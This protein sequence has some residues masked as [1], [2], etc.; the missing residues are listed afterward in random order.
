MKLYL[1]TDTWN[2]ANTAGGSST[3]TINAK[4]GCMLDLQI[5][6]D[7]DLAEGAT[8]VLTCKPKSNYSSTVIA[9]DLAWTEI[10]TG[11]G[12]YL[13]QLDLNTSDALALFSGTSDSVALMAD[14]TITAGGEVHKTQTFS[15]V[16]G[17][18]V[19]T[20]DD[21]SP[22]EVPN[23]KAVLADA[24]DPT[25]DTHWTTQAKVAQ[26]ISA[27]AHPDVLEF[28]NLSG[29]PATGDAAV[30]YLAK[31]TE[32]VYR[33]DAGTTSYIQVAPPTVTSV[34]GQTGAVTIAVGT[35]PFT[36]YN[37]TNLDSGWFSGAAGGK[38][39]IDTTSGPAFC[40][41]P[42]SPTSG[43]TIEF[44]DA[45]GTWNAHSFTIDRNGKSIEGLAVNYSD[46]AQG[47]QFFVVYIDDTT[48]WKIYESGTKP[49]ILVAPATPSGSENVG[50]VLTADNGTWTGSPT[51]YA[52]Q[53][54]DSPDGTTWTPISGATSSAYT[55]QSSAIGLYVSVLV[56]AV[57]SNGSSLQS[58]SGATAVIAVPSFPF[59]CSDYWTLAS[60]FTNSVRDN[61][62]VVTGGVDFTSWSIGNMATKEGDSDQITSV[63]GS[64][65]TGNFS[66]NYWIYV[67][68]GSTNYNQEFNC[69][70][71]GMSI[72]ANKDPYATYIGSYNLVMGTTPAGVGVHMASLTFDGTTYRIYLDGVLIASQTNP[73][74]GANSFINFFGGEYGALIATA[75]GRVGIW[76]SRALSDA[77]IAALY[78]G[79]TPPAYA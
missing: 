22:T 65:L 72:S 63:Q 10:T 32:L 13:F 31:D 56:T 8:G 40:Q 48:G 1:A 15:I 26:A 64:N 33:W 75:I 24:F 67:P 38:Y 68:D 45:K 61:D 55:L 42:A 6:P 7:V 20:T 29:F 5:I 19:S 25:D 39:A 17:Q 60:D 53:W 77:E 35:P 37:D 57:N 50:S 73:S 43:D 49:H 71:L 66:I 52:Y 76:D 46:S 12:G 70:A 34:N 74:I 21:G 4:A 30:L 78:G 69:S 27:A 41:L 54:Q 2:L 58:Q 3:L 36:L 47:T 16:L 44:C 23:L 28:A 14:I 11:D 18:P 9:R 62:F 59:G 79:G 51:G